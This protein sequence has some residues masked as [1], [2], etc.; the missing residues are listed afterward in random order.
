MSMT[1]VESAILTRLVLPDSPSMDSAFAK[2]V[3]GL[4]FDDEDRRLMNEL[5]AKAR[6]GILTESEQDELDSYERVGH[7]LSLLKSKARRSL[8]QPPQN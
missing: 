2:G 6:D 5:S 4:S 1:S 3:L 8:G 7:F